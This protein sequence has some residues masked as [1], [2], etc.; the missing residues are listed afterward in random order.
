MEWMVLVYQLKPG[1]KE[2]P[3]RQWALPDRIF[4]G[5]GACHIL[6][7]VFLK[8]NRDPTWIALWIKPKEG[9]RGNH[10]IVTDGNI[11][12]DYHGYSRLNRLLRHHKKTWIEHAGDWRAEILR[13]DFSLL[14][15]MALNAR[16]MRGPDQYYGDAVKRSHRFIDRFDHDRLKKRAGAKRQKLSLPAK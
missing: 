12:F 5:Y 9:F 7:G 1:I 14:D 13:V 16:N 11:A 8:W 15:T 3:G 6:A 2:D 4:F 10:I